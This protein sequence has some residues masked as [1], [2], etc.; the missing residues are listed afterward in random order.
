MFLIIYHPWASPSGTS[1][2]V[3]HMDDWIMRS[4]SIDRPLPYPKLLM[5]RWRFTV[6]SP[7]SFGCRHF[8]K[9]KFEDI[10][11]ITNIFS[12]ISSSS[13]SIIVYRVY[14]SV[15]LLILSQ[16]VNILS[17]SSSSILSPSSL[18]M[19]YPLASSILLPSVSYI[20]SLLVL[21]MSPPL[22]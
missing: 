10:K 3:F 9:L 18:S 6:G 7:V 16:Y 14:S 15:G 12:N 20:L 8:G 5:I 21:S 19:S 22:T 11:D 2:A 4:K 1:H 17:P 13:I